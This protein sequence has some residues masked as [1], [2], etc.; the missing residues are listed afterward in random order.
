M[1][2]DPHPSFSEI[3]IAFFWKTSE[4]V[5]CKGQKSA[6]YLYINFLIDNYHTY[7][8]PPLWN[9]P[10]NSSILVPLPVPYRPYIAHKNNLVTY[11]IFGEVEEDPFGCCK[12]I[13]QNEWGIW[14]WKWPD[15]LQITSFFAVTKSRPFNCTFWKT[16]WKLILEF[17]CSKVKER[18]LTSSIM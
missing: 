12:K 6:I 7:S 17:L 9:F 4:K 14:F 18:H 5:L 10:D 8:P 3:D 16:D 1:V 2:F 15:L 11:Y 13:V